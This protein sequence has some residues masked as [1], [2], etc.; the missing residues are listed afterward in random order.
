MKTKLQKLCKALSLTDFTSNYPVEKLPFWNSL[1][2]ILCLLGEFHVNLRSKHTQWYRYTGIGSHQKSREIF[3]ERETPINYI[4]KLTIY[5]WSEYIFWH[6][7][8]KSNKKVTFKTENCKGRCRSYFTNV[9]LDF[10][11]EVPFF[12]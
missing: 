1:D 10:T 3:R 7:V 11:C 9:N 5:I 2:G 12:V 8:H 6:H 4:R